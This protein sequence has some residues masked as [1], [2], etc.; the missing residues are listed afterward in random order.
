VAFTSA[1]GPA[2]ASFRVPEVARWLDVL[3]FDWGPEG[4]PTFDDE[5]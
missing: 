5:V 3:G 1:E 2:T 4:P